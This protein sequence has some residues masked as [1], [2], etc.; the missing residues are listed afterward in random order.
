MNKIQSH[1]RKAVNRTFLINILMEARQ[2]HS[3]KIAS[4]CI[5]ITRLQNITH[6]EMLIHLINL[7]GAHNLLLVTIRFKKSYSIFQTILVF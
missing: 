4:F 3:V 5:K 1:S 7:V 2:L 6:F